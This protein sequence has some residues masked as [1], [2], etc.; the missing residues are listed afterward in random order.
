MRHIFPFKQAEK[1]NVIKQWLTAESLKHV[2]INCHSAIVGKSFIT[3]EISP[4]LY[5]RHLN[6]HKYLLHKYYNVMGFGILINL[7]SVKNA[8]SPLISKA[9]AISA[10]AFL[11]ATLS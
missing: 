8:Y 2:E 10:I 1:L 7:N 9:F 6:A 5:Y 3:I 11:L 4:I